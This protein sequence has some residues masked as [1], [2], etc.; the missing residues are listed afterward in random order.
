MTSATGVSGQAV[1]RGV[2]WRVVEVIGSEILAFGAFVLL[3]RL[4]M[5]DHFGVVSQ[6]TLFILSAQLL[7]QQGLPEALVQKQDIGE[8]HVDSCFWANLALGACAAL[9]LTLVAPLVAFL[10]AEP[11]LSPVLMA[12]SPTLILLA[13]SRIILARLRRAFR[14][15]GFMAL[16]VA[17]TLAGALA[18]VGL[19]AGGYGVWSLVAQQWTYATVGLI[20]GCLVAKWTPSLRF[21]INHVREMWAFSSFTVLEAFLAF[22]AR[23]LDL[24][25]LAV[26]WSA[27]EVGFYF[28]ANRLLFSA[29]MLT[30]Y[31]ISHLGLPFLAR[32]VSDEEAYRE[33]IYRTMRLVSLACLPSLIGLALVAPLFVPVLFGDVW[34]KSVAPFQALAAFSIF[35]A[36]VLMGGQVL[37]SAGHARDAMILSAVAMVLFLIAV[38]LAAPFGI[39]WAAISGGLANM[40]VLPIY[41]LQLKRRFNLDPIRLIREQMPCW[42]A[43]LAMTAVIKSLPESLHLSLAP[44]THLLVQIV[45]GALTFTFAIFVLSRRE[46]LDIYATIKDR[47]HGSPSAIDHSEGDGSKDGL[48]PHRR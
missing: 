2:F 6:A 33:A 40:L 36:F 13:A 30:Y 20:A 15:E 1:V 34:T 9:L 35:Y 11:L 39:V 4:L 37:I 18:A 3:A 24:L 22:C 32:L 44:T 28:L 8:A 41:G 19:A 31:S 42:L 48:S 46:I 47:D 21:D 12:L 27:H 26:F 10:L 7:L 14:F 17:A 45:I 23:R 25:I 43:V 16:N 29:G 5:P 38:S